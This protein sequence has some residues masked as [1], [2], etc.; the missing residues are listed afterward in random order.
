ME[1][2]DSVLVADLRPLCPALGCGVSTDRGG[3]H[4][5]TPGPSRAR[6]GRYRAETHYR[7]HLDSF[8]P[9]RLHS[10]RP[11]AHPWA[12]ARTWLESVG[13]RPHGDYADKSLPRPALYFYSPRKG[14]GKTHLAAAIANAVRTRGKLVAFLEETSYLERRWSCQF[15]EV[16]RLTA[17]PGDHAWLTVIDDLGQ[18]GKASES[19]ADAWYA[20][21]NRRWLKQGWTIFTSNRLPE[22]LVD[23]GTINEA[24]YSRLMHMIGKRVVFFDGEDQRLA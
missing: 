17:L 22:E 21:I 9:E 15:S 1:G 8:Q 6:A 7:L 11:E 12:I 14:C 13:D 18:R 3:R 19:V 24:T 10:S 4:G 2:R 16:E 23:Q 5:R 20:V